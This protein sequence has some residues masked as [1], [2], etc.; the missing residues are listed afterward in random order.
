M[1]QKEQIFMTRFGANLRRERTACGI[2]Q[3]KLAEM[4]DLNIRTVQKIEAGRINI[5]ITTAARLRKAV[6]CSWEKLVA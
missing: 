3:Q 6:G 4:A 5:L 1:H 2:T